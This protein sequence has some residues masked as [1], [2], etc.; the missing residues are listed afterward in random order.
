MMNLRKLLSVILTFSLM[1]GF[2]TGQTDSLKKTNALYWTFEFGISLLTNTQLIKNKPFYGLNSISLCWYFYY[3]IPL[4]HRNADE[5][6]HGFSIAPGL[7]FGYHSFGFDKQLVEMKGISEFVDFNGEYKYS[8]FGGMFIDIPLDLRYL[9]RL[10]SKNQNFSFELGAKFGYLVFTQKEYAIQSGNDLIRTTTNHLN[11][12][13]NI[14]YGINSKFSFRHLRLIIVKNE[15]VGFSYSLIMN[16]YPSSF[17]KKDKG[18]ETPYY[19]IGLGLSII[20]K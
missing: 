14:R 7:G 6:N 20:F 2:A 15:Y 3:D 12:F 11:S 1:H 5:L 16:Y 10:N 8:S 4:G 19:S 17:F 18:P 9:T 13:N